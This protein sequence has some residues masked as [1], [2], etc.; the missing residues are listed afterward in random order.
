MIVFGIDSDND[1]EFINA[2]LLRY[3]QERNLRLHG[4]YFQPV[5]KLVSKERNGSQVKKKYD[6]ART[7]YQ[8]LLESDEQAAEL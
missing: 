2:H 4:N 6:T 8:R 5:M 3:R 1:G 7:P